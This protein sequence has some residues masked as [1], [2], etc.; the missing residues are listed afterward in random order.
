VLNK[1]NKLKTVS[2]LNTTIYTVS[3]LSVF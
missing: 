3:T 2:I 1:L